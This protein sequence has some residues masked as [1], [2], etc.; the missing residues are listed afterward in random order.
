MKL[1]ALL[2]TPLLL[3]STLAS[4]TLA[5]RPVND[6]FAAA[7][8]ITGAIPVTLSGTN[9]GATRQI[10]DD[11]TLIG[12]ESIWWKWTPY[13]STNHVVKATGQGF[14]VRLA[15]YTLRADGT[16]DLISSSYQ[17]GA[18]HPCAVPVPAAN[19]QTYYFVASSIEGKPT[20]EI[21]LEID[22]L[23]PPA[24]D[25]WIDA[26]LIPPGFP[27][28]PSP[29]T[30]LEPVRS[31]MSLAQATT[32]PVYGGNGPPPPPISSTFLTHAMP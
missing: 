3:L 6:D 7:T 2:A 14:D 8:I 20:G 24:N 15:V 28:P 17:Q 23:P 27:S 11:A 19:A 25:D 1:L 5:Q 30:S 9:R 4:R 29:T 10:Q 31:Q 32:V 16:R 12:N 13:F 18:T 22:F 26:E 21:S